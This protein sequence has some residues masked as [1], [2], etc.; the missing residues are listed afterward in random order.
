V[1]V[2][3]RPAPGWIQAQFQ[4]RDMADGRMIEDGLLWDSQGHLIAQSRQLA[5]LL[6]KA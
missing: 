2:R 1:N 6:K 5:L 4:T 3:R